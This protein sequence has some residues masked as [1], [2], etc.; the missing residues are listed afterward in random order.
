MRVTPARFKL[1]HLMVGVAIVAVGLFAVDS[2]QVS[3]WI[4]FFPL[5][6]SLTSPDGRRIVAVEYAFAGRWKDA[7]SLKGDPKALDLN[8]LDVAWVEGAPFQLS[9][10]KTGQ[11][12]L[13]GRE[14]SYYQPRFLVLRVTYQDGSSELFPVRIPDSRVGRKVTVTIPE[15]KPGS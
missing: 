7:K 15:Q 3:H 5:D 12:T 8:F 14:T 4:G 2:S 11:S 9:V 1:I 6:V 10:Q 13:L